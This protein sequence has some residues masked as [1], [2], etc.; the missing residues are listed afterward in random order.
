MLKTYL[1]IDEFRNN[2]VN[3]TGFDYYNAYD[4]IAQENYDDDLDQKLYRRIEDHLLT[5]IK[6]YAKHDVYYRGDLQFEFED[7]KERDKF[8]AE[9]GDPMAFKLKWV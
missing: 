2:C 9:C 1:E 8:D 5:W 4:E 6:E 7:E 3:Y